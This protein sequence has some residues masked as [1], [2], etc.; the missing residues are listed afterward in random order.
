[1]WPWGHWGLGYLCYVGLSRARGDGAPT[2]AAALAVTFGTVAPDLVDK[3][4]AWSL[5]VLPNGRSLAHSLVLAG[6]VLVVLWVAARRIDRAE[7]VVALAVGYLSHLAGDALYP[8]LAGDWGALAF[9]GWPLLPPVG[10]ASEGGFL[11]NLLALDLGPTAWAELAL[12]GLGLAV[13]I[14][15]GLPGRPRLAWLAA[16]PLGEH[17]ED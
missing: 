11:A 17:T 10:Y 5:G 7:P 3:P 6:A 13:W 8:A 4:L 1:M 12:F 9:L 16:G 2:E 14:G 15:Q